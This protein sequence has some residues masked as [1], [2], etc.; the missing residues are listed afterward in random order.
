MIYLVSQQNSCMIIACDK[1]LKSIFSQL[2]CL[3]ID[4]I[5]EIYEHI[6]SAFVQAWLNILRQRKYRYK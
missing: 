5:F 1:L 2:E 3:N 6:L 4:Q